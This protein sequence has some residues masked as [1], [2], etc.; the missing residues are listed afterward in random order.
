MVKPSLVKRSNN[1]Q[2]ARVK[3]LTAKKRAEREFAAG[4]AE[5]LRILKEP[6]TPLAL[7]EDI[8]PANLPTTAPKDAS[9]LKTPEVIGLYTEEETLQHRREVAYFHATGIMPA[10]FRTHP[11]ESIFYEYPRYLCADRR[12]WD[13]H[14]VGNQARTAAQGHYLKTVLD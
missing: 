7:V 8:G 5:A 1:K 11:R 10:R 13:V 12:P 3:A 2:R 6:D 9:L 4:I 14:Y